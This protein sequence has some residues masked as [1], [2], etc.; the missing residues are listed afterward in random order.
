[1]YPLLQSPSPLQDTEARD[2]RGW[3]GGGRTGDG[4]GN[5]D[6]VQ[7]TN[8]ASIPYSNPPSPLARHPKPPSSRLHS[9]QHPHP[10]N[11]MHAVLCVSFPAQSHPH[12]C[13]ASHPLPPLIHLLLH[14]PSARPH[15]SLLSAT[16]SFHY[17]PLGVATAGQPSMSVFYAF[18]CHTSHKHVSLHCSHKLSLR[19]PSPPSTILHAQ[20]LHSCLASRR[21]QI[22]SVSPL[23]LCPQEPL[24]VPTLI[25][26]YNI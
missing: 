13:P 8:L 23:R 25:H 19:S 15:P 4:R 1:M 20:V 11:T 18:L 26:H 10:S 7:H 9:I 24:A 3:Q 21:A 12:V 6:T 2:G 22:T 5:R 17:S 14:C 16:T